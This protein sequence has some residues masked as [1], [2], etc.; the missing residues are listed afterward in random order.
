M[1][2]GVVGEDVS[3]KYGAAEGT[4]RTVGAPGLL[5]PTP[6]SRETEDGAPDSAA[7]NVGGDDTTA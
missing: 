6:F 1:V 7:S 4:R 2:V 5:V 3:P